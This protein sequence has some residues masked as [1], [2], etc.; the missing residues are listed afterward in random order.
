MS[1]GERVLRTLQV[2]QQQGWDKRSEDCQAGELA[3]VACFYSLAAAEYLGPGRRLALGIW[4]WIS[5]MPGPEQSHEQNLALAG[6]FILM[7]LE[8]IQKAREGESGLILPGG[9]G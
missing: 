1:P 6:A 5:E 7:E 2:L 4:P 8:R 3:G 9:R